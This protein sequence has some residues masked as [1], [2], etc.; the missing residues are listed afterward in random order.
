M[1]IQSHT[2]ILNIFPAIP[3]TWKDVSFEKL[4]TMGA[5]LVSAKMIS[6]T[7]KKVE[8][9]SE[10]GGMFQMKNPFHT[11]IYNS[12]EKMETTVLDNTIKINMAKGQTIV[13]TSKNSGRIEVISK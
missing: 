2:G 6:G 11:E 10:T 3:N 8:V 12:E 1:L 9:F 13:F 7:L 5:F 4:K